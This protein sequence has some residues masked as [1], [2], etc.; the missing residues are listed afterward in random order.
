MVSKI[1]SRK[2]PLAILEGYLRD[3][4]RTWPN[5]EISGKLAGET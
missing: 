1:H 5:L 4:R 2:L 3:F